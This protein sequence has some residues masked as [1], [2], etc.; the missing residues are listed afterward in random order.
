MTPEQGRTLI[1]FVRASIAE[2]FG[3]PKVQQPSGEEW[4][5]VP[6]ALFV[7]LHR[8][9]DLR[10]CI[11]TMEPRRSL[12]DEVVDKA[13]AAA[14][15]DPRMMPVEA[16]ELPELDIEITLLHPLE[17]IDA[18]TE[19]ELLP[20]LRP[21]VDG[22]VLRSRQGSAL[23]LPSVWKELPEPKAFVRALM[24]KA[25]LFRWPADLRALRFA[26]D[27]VSAAPVKA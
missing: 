27:V 9:G 11:G 4:L 22:L 19:E 15:D 14:F 23:F 3:G 20:Q 24:Y 10:G 16:H 8:D 13:K 7:T 21:H 1:E 12:F 25:H 2:Q 5:N 26:A 6:T 18:R 17:P